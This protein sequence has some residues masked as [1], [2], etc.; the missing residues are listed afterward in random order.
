MIQ[1]VQFA[2]IHFGAQNDAALS[3]AFQTVVTLDP[4]AI[5][6]CGD[7][8]QRG[9]KVEFEAAK[10]WLAEF[11]TPMLVVPGNHDTPLL[12]LVARVVSPFDRFEEHFSKL[13][14]PIKIEGW[15][16]SGLNTARGWQVR[17]NW[18]E[19][20]VEL[21]ALDAVISKETETAAM[22][23]CHHPFLPYE[24]AP[25]KLTTARGEEASARLARSQFEILLTGHVHAP[26]SNVRRTDDG[27]YLAITAGTLSSR[28]RATPPSFNVIGLS[29]KHIEA[30]AYQFVDNTFYPTCLGRWTRETLEP[31]AGSFV[32]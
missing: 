18:A 28:T 14:R 30:T 24:G 16:A 1:I 23:V 2:D 21:D 13:S 20:S 27:A 3:A 5:V 26:S 29:D 11:S 15:R 31:M 6:V 25:L 8:T 7:L 19:G 9:K 4:D 10:I 32:D 12:N 22:L 17:A